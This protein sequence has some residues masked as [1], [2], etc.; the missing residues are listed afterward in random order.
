MFRVRLWFL[1]LWIAVANKGANDHHVVVWLDLKT[2]ILLELT[3]IAI[4]A[5]I[6][7][8]IVKKMWNDFS[9]LG[10]YEKDIVG[11][12]KKTVERSVMIIKALLM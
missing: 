7:R 8:R 9:E 5:L 12:T 10:I 11:I 6:D 3:R 2:S 1:R 4:N